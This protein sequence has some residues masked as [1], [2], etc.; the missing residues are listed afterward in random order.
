[1]EAVPIAV[2]WIALALAAC[3][4]RHVSIHLFF[5]TM[6]FG[7]FAVIP[8]ELTGGL[9]LTPTPVVAS[10]LVGR[11]LLAPGGPARALVLALKPSGLFYLSQFWLVA[12]IATVFMPRLYGGA[13]EVIPVRPAGL[14][15]A[16]MLAPSAQ[17]LSQF[18]YVTI[19]VLAVFA[20]ARLL[21]SERD[22][23]HAMQ[24]LCLGAGI[25][26]ASGI[27]DFSSKF[28][29]VQPL[30]DAFRTASY[31]LM[32]D[33]EILDS[34]RVVG[35]M[36]EASSYGALLLCFLPALYFFRR[37]MPAGML[38]DRIVPLQCCALLVLVWLSTSSSAYL[39]LAAFAAVAVAEWTWRFLA[40][41]RNPLLRRGIATEFCAGLAVA[42]TILLLLIAVPRVFSPLVE[43]LDVMVFQKSNSSSFEERSLWN[44]VSWNALW[45]TGGLGVGLGGTRASNFA[46]AV[47]SNAGIVGAALYFTFV[48]RCL[49][50]GKAPHA[51]VRG[52]AIL[53]ACRC[54]YVPAFLAILTV[55]TTPDF[56]L[57][58][59]FLY[60][61]AVAVA[62][63][64]QVQP[65]RRPQIGRWHAR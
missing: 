6:P 17:N 36:P 47:A 27:L 10:M 1:M 52:Q 32:T 30:L 25:A 4:P 42:A 3:R 60:G 50:F 5:A 23:L 48:L 64:P 58:N 59:A 56:G 19:S 11:E 8:T 31:T 41:R 12:G 49:F 24:A 34:R 7:S 13:V 61:F 9:T 39:G 20:F 53:S 26:I 46:I 15:S 65:R 54:A 51:D 21:R 38:R 37:A 33:N 18:V 57:F 45:A 35:L 28:V 2:F 16:A 63:G 44:T 14:V 29:P 55:G 43:M 62:V 22:R 40:A